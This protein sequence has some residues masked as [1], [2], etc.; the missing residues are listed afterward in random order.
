MVAEPA[1]ERRGNHVE[2]KERRGQRAHLL[3]GR[4]ELTLDERHFAGQNV[5]VDV[6][7]QVEADEQEQSPRAG[8][9]RGRVGRMG[10]QELSCASEV[11]EEHRRSFDITISK[12]I[13]TFEAPFA[14]DDRP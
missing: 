9:R 3:I 4:V 14:Q 10:R 11:L 1:G 6:V 13:A 8:L 2:E 7:Q 12:L 5:A